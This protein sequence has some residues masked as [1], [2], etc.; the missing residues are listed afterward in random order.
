MDSALYEFTDKH[1]KETRINKAE[2]MRNLM[3][4]LSTLSKEL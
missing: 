1:L 2:V 4:N 3:Q